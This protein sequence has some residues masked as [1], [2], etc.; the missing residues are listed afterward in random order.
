MK[1]VLATLAA[2][3]LALSVA[4][5][6]TPAPEAQAAPVVSTEVPFKVPPRDPLCAWP[7]PKAT[8]KDAPNYIQNMI[9]D[10]ERCNDVKLG[11]EVWGRL[12]GPGHVVQGNKATGAN[13]PQYFKDNVPAHNK[14]VLDGEY[15][16]AVQPWLHITPGPQNQATNTRV[17]MTPLKVHILRKSTNKWVTLD[18]VPVEGGDYNWGLSEWLRDS[19]LKDTTGQNTAVLPP[20]D[21]DDQGKA[22][23]FHGWGT[24][25]EIDTADIKAINV[26][27]KARLVVD[28]SKKADDRNKAQYLVQIGGDYYPE[29]NTRHGD[30]GGYFPGIGLSRAKL[31]TN[32]WRTFNFINIDTAKQEPGGS[33][34]LDE[35]W[36]NPPPR[37]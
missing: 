12:H 24:P 31:V 1:K 37:S 23:L 18:S 8:V 10:M 21:R 36:K 13:T 30:L 4:A 5:V 32:E 17:E 27:M 11:D 14:H 20:R 2:G 7:T 22:S 19:N 6:A 16:G 29:V 28:D 3:T 9:D 15:W 34:T 25:T 35:L 33:I 26:T